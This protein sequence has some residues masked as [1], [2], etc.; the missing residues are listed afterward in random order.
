MKTKSQKEDVLLLKEFLT[1]NKEIGF[2]KI[3]NKYYKKIRVKLM[4]ASRDEFLADDLVNEIFMKVYTKLE[5][6]DPDKAGLYTWINSVA[7]NHFRD[8]LR[9]E[10][11]KRELFV[12]NISSSVNSDGVV[13]THQFA[14]SCLNPEECIGKTERIDIL[15]EAIVNSIK[16]QS[17][18]DIVYLRYFDEFSY[19]EIAVRT[20]IPVGTIKSALFRARNLMKEYFEE[21]S[22]KELM[23]Y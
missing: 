12:N 2:K 13:I 16:K 1:G 14:D 4:I 20:K 22:I 6:F 11:K 10:S 18:R 21:V 15:K 19:D 9:K 8:Y 5:S 23:L 17:I 3:Y 7:T